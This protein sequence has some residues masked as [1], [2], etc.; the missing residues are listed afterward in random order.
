MTEDELR[1][2]EARASAAT[3]GP[4]RKTQDG[5][6]WLYVKS[7]ASV[8]SITH[9]EYWFEGPEGQPTREGDERNFAFIAHARE[10]VPALIAE[11]RRMRQNTITLTSSMGRVIDVH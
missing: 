6:T 10:D 3:P 2:I 1:E 8:T 7:E 9:I 11:I 4:W 5:K